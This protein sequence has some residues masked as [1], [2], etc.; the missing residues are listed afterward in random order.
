MARGQQLENQSS[1]KTE[2]AAEVCLQQNNFPKA[3][4]PV[5]LCRSVFIKVGEYVLPD[6]KDAHTAR[7][8]LALPSSTTTSV[9]MRAARAAPTAVFEKAS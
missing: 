1:A 7:R 3:G 4:V 2:S 8:F 6:R 5:Q 9:R